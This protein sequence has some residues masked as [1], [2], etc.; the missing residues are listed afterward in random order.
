MVEAK[1]A[2]FPFP[3]NVLH[4]LDLDRRIERPTGQLEKAP[5]ARVQERRRHDGRTH[6]QKERKEGRAEEKKRDGRG[7]NYNEAQTTPNSFVKIM[8]T[9]NI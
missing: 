7:N 9:I 5:N 8:F 3:R 2:R 1:N 4:P 6:K